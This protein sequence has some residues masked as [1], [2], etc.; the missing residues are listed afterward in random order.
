MN[1]PQPPA[2]EAR[3]EQVELEMDQD[4]PLCTLLKQTPCWQPFL[5]FHK[6]SEFHRRRGEDIVGPC[7]KY[8]L[9]LQACLEA[10]ADRLPPEIA[11]QRWQQKKS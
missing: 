7:A 10:N 4:C 5:A 2:L 1:Q 11:S 3:Y 9:G 8:A 6:C